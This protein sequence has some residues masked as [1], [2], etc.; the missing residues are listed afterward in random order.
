MDISRDLKEQNVG[1]LI[2]YRNTENI[3]HPDSSVIS[4]TESRRRSLEERNWSLD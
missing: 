2:W 3:A 4:M 1:E